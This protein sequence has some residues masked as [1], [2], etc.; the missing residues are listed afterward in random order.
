VTQS[1]LAKLDATQAAVDRHQPDVAVKVLG[2]CI[3][4]VEAQAGEHIEAEHAQHLVEH[5]QL[6]IQTLDTT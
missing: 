5:A 2:A 3:H 1:R 6:V 4:E